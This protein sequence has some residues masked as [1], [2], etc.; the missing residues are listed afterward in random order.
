MEAAIQPERRVGIQG[1]RAL[2]CL[3]VL[4]QHVTFF[5]AYAKG[6]DYHP[7]LVV[8]FGRIGVSLFF[9]ISGFVMGGCLGQGRAFLWNRVARI[10][11]AFWIA[12]AL[13]FLI[14][15]RAEPAW[16]LDW[17]SLLLLPSTALNNSYRIPYWTLCYEFAFYCVTYLMIVC[18]LSRT[19][20]LTACTIWLL[21]IILMDAYRP[22][23]DIDDGTA[24]GFV[25][26]PGKWILLTPYPIFFI[27][28]L[29]TSVAG[30]QFA[31]RVRPAYL[32]L[33]AIGVWGVSN[34]I[35]FPSPAPL[36]LMQA[37]AFCSAVI[38]VQ[39]LEF[40]RIYKSL[41]DFSYGFYLVHM[42]I[43]AAVIYALK[44]Y[45]INIR[46]SVLWIIVAISASIGGLLYGWIEHEIHNRIFK[47]I[48]RRK[49]QPLPPLRSKQDV[50]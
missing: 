41:G 8:N 24:F 34:S 47:R 15:L 10:F 16:H 3:F 6:L 20:I 18:R 38:A 1:L 7:Y 49:S 32:V 36:F 21:A 4:F 48:F 43:I 13:S 19:Q 23:G 25:A 30:T 45:A 39:N 11:P 12:V 31:D 44:P 2:A 42:M 17:R 5:V 14:L 40:S 50:A 46:F 9:V 27:A 33:L 29:F 26:Q 28:G 35:K 37:F 22:L